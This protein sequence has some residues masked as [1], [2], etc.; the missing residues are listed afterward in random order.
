[1]SYNV[2]LYFSFG[3]CPLW[4]LFFFDLRI[5]ITT[6]VSSNYSNVNDFIY[7]LD[8]PTAPTAFYVVCKTTS[9]V[10]LWKSAFN[11]GSKQ[12]FYVQHWRISQSSPS[13]LS[14][15][16]PD[17]GSASVLPY[18]V[19][20]LVPYTI[21]IFQVIARNDLGDSSSKSMTCTTDQSM[22]ELLYNFRS[23]SVK[24]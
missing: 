10:V 12:E 23:I 9:A 18:T 24:C 1:M 17:S 3:N 16:I 11:G 7:I 21:Y 8:K 15:T 4:C 22:Y 14:P 2:L 13:M 20:N 19:N 6:L 5:L